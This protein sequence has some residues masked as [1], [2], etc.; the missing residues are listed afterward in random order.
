MFGK[1]PYNGRSRAEIRDQILARQAFIKPENCPKGWTHTAVDFINELIQRKPYKRLGK[2]GILELK[3]HDW[4][5]GFDWENLKNKKMKPPFVP[6]VKNVFDYLKNLTEDF[7]EMENSLENSFLI[8]SESFQNM[9]MEYDIKPLIESKT[10]NEMKNKKKIK[11]NSS[12]NTKQ[13]KSKKRT[14][15]E[16]NKETKSVKKLKSSSKKSLISST[17]KKKLK[18]R[19]HSSKKNMYY[20]LSLSKRKRENSFNEYKSKGNKSLNHVPINKYSKPASIQK[21]KNDLKL[22]LRLSSKNIFNQSSNSIYRENINPKYE[23]MKNIRLNKNYKNQY[24]LKNNYCSSSNFTENKMN[25]TML[26]NSI[27]YSNLNFLKLNKN[28]SFSKNHNINQSIDQMYQKPLVY[29]DNNKRMSINGS[30]YNKMRKTQKKNLLKERNNSSF[31][32][33]SHKKKSS[34]YLSK[35][36][37]SQRSKDKKNHFSHFYEINNKILSPHQS[38]TLKENIHKKIRSSKKHLPISGIDLSLINKKEVLMKSF[39]NKYSNLKIFNKNQIKNNFDL[40]NNFC[41]KFIYK[42]LQNF[43]K[44]KNNKLNSKK[45]KSSSKNK[46]N[47]A[48]WN[49]LQNLLYKLP[50]RE[51]GLNSN[52]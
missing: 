16:S 44:K 39:N 26:M 22:K 10:N 11:N 5:E 9:F 19:K 47:I 31:N 14:L 30:F 52:N 20:N 7:T 27:N 42:K 33:I 32:T 18:E 1:R 35:K 21:I 23:G 3:Q 50:N 17:N 8:K 36:K 38:F 28:K 2:Q 29:Q 41:K 15:I 12:K 49:K 51:Y 25:S 46:D 45:I 37:L 34:F 43:T 13:E 4:F 48:Q 40:K 6:N 24:M